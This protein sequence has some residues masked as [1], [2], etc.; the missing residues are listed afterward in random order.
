MKRRDFL[1][2][3][4]VLGAAPFIGCGRNSA[5]ILPPGTLGGSGFGAGHRLREKAFGQPSEF[6]KLPLLI[7]G[8]GVAGLSAAWR[9]DRAGFKDYLILDLEDQ[10]GGNARHGQNGVSAYPLGAHYLP[11][12]TR[13]ATAVRELL[14]DLGALAGDARAERPSYDERLLCHSPQERIYRDGIWEEGLLP[15]L[16]ADRAERDQ[17]ARFHERMDEFKA[18]RD[19]L[20]RRAFALPVALAS[21]DARWLG[22]ETVTMAEWLVANGFNSERLH[23]YVNYACRDDYG[24]D[25]RQTSAWAGI[26][27][28]ACRNGQAA[29]AAADAVLTAPE[30]N[31]WIVGRLLERVRDRV[32]TGALC[33]RLSQSSQAVAADVWLAAENRSVRY[34][35]G[36]AIWA[37]PLF[38][39]PHVAEGLPEGVA[40]VARGGDYAP[41]LLANLSLRELPSP[42][43]G[44]P[45]SWDNVLYDAPGLGYVVATHQN[46]RIAPGPTVLTYY[47]PLS[48]LPSSKAREMLLATSREA[49][50]S[51]ILD[52]LSRAH[53]DLRALTTQL[54]VF[55]HG[56]AMIRP[57]PGV[58]HDPARQALTR[59]WGRI[60]FAHADLSGLSLFEEANYHGVR[61]GEAVMSRLAIPYSTFLA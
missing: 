49:W 58:I 14:S 51:E 38:V 53:G 19:F 37:A 15:R 59:G 32:V 30:G 3:T 26:H 39:L 5:A 10:V 50:A 12:P 11:L 6:R 57:T 2:A 25:Y 60:H 16:G 7:I 46:V 1:T 48:E 13:E 40:A 28:F 34:L 54:D 4:A 55:R 24:T 17:F 35:A 33:H 44:A 41:W 29:N 8:A 18:A 21:R 52:E 47:R 42:G 56:H 27:Y 36:Q 61:A 45:L 23:W 31:G 9:L 22:L 43:A 20:G